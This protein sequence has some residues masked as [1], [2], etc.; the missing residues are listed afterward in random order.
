[1]LLALGNHMN[2]GTPKGQADGFTLFDLP[3]TS[4]TKDN[5]NAITLLEYA[6]LRLC[7]LPDA[8]LATKLP[9]QLPHLK[10][11]AKVE[12]PEVRGNL[13]QLVNDAKELQRNASQFDDGG[14]DGGSSGPFISAMR[15]FS[16][17]AEIRTSRQKPRCLPSG[18]TQHRAC[19]CRGR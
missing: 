19:G 4:V 14:G 3:K 15:D 13:Q 7:A 18:P 12:M 17:T 10:A 9:D 2:A 8:P 1:M 16:V 11:A 6:V 5:T